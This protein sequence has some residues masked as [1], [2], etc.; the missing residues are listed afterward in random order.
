[1]PSGRGG[2][3]GHAGSEQK[4]PHTRLPV[5]PGVR[6]QLMERYDARFVYLAVVLTN[7]LAAAGTETDSPVRIAFAS[8]GLP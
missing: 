1:M 2:P 8:R 4:N 3:G 6:V 7:D 5:E